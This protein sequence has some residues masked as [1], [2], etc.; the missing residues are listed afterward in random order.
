MLLKKKKPVSMS[1]HIRN[2][3][4]EYYKENDNYEH[5]FDSPPENN[6]KE[7]SDLWLII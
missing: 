5:T 6:A 3:S 2:N 4:P 7:K 1:Q